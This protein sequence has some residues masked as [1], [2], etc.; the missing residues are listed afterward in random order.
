MT[1]NPK[2][3]NKTAYEG[4][5]TNEYKSIPMFFP[6]EILWVVYFTINHPFKTVTEDVMAWIYHMYLRLM[7]VARL[8]KSLLAAIFQN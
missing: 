2:W 7:A 6:D 3:F 4:S 5:N 1:I 8:V